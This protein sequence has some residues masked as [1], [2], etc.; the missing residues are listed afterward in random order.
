MADWLAKLRKPEAEKSGT[1]AS[2][3]EKQLLELFNNR[4]ELKR[5]YDRT[6][7]ERANL[8]EEVTELRKSNTEMAQ[9]LDGLDKALADPAKAQ[10]V[11]VY[12]GLERLW[13][14]CQRQLGA[15]ATEIGSRLEKQEREAVLTQH[16]SG[17]EAT[18]RSMDERLGQVQGIRE[19]ALQRI[20]Q[21]EEQLK[22]ATGFWNHFKRKKLSA[23]LVQCRRDAQPLEE[24]YSE[25]AKQRDK[26]RGTQPPQFSGLSLPAR[27]MLN[28]YIIAA[29][30][31]YYLYFAGDDLSSMAHL[32]RD[33]QP[34][35]ANYGN[36]DTCL[37]LQRSIYETCNAF[38]ADPPKMEQLRNRVGLLQKS[39]KFPDADSAMPEV[40]SLG[41]IVKGAKSDSGL[42]NRIVANVLDLNSWGIQAFLLAK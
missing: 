10:N 2:A 8:L 23:E 24:R 33:K 4:N 21:L 41:D 32:A 20:K 7:A 25:Y 35:E 37:K 17:L 13:N 36:T 28:L 26:L 12:Y 14:L 29:A 31:Q 3:Q 16:R 1:G 40:T 18:M 30:Q 38:A 27:R 5:V 15:M 34:H 9:R 6:L 22:T 39:T 19:D 42:D 11:L